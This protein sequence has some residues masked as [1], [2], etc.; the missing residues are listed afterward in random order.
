ECDDGND[1]DTDDCTNM[2]LAAACG[3]LI[4]HELVEQCDDG[5]DIDTDECT[6]ACTVAVCGDSVVQEGKEQCDDG[7]DVDTDECTN[8]CTIAA[9]GDNVVQAGEEQC[10]DGNDVDTDDC[11]SLCLNAACGDGFVQA[12]EQC[13]DGNVTA[14]DGCSDVCAIDS[15]YVFVSSQMYDGNLGGL[16]GADAKCQALADAANLP[17][18]YM[19][20]VSTN[21]AN[22]SPATRFT[23]SPT[24]YVKV[25][26]VKVADNW[27]DL[28]D[29]VLDSAIDKT[30]LGGA[31]PIGDTS[32]NGGGSAT[33]WSATNTN[34]TFIDVGIDYNCTNWTSN[35]LIPSLWGL[36]TDPNSA[37]T[38]WCSGGI[39]SWV[40]PIYCF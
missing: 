1:V 24:P 37:W 36:A 26:G 19:A 38:N 8:A 39:C 15:K 3:D 28:I 22:G 10:D 17:G 32:C 7:N 9:C 11:T 4:V 30:E 13:D 18:T 29:G 23:Q 34:G 35:E 20:W 25:D 33:V 6:N 12:G 14:G 27:A 31:P 21:E 40:S 5:N 2:C 16:A